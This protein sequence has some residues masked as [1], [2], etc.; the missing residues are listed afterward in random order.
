MIFK[1]KSDKIKTL[2]N[3]DTFKDV[4]AQVMERQ[5]AVF[6]DVHSTKDERDDAHDIVRALDKITSYMSS[7][8]DD[9]KISKKRK[10][11]K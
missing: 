4:I 5:I 11:K 9:E 8:I 10:R 1:E 7:V 2:I 3:D 6:M